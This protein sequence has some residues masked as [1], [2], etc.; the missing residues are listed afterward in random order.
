MDVQ[1]RL[2]EELAAVSSSSVSN[3]SAQSNILS[4]PYLDH[5]I[6]ETLRL[7]PPNQSTVRAAGEDC[8][9]PTSDGTEVFIRKGQFIHIAIEGF[10]TRK[11]VWGTDSFVFRP[12]R[13]AEEDVVRALKAT[14]GV[15]Q[16]LMTFSMGP[17]VRDYVLF[18][19]DEAHLTIS[20]SVMSR[21]PTR[22][23]RDEGLTRCS[24]IRVCVRTS[25]WCQSGDEQCVS[26]LL[27]CL[28]ETHE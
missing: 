11:D 7:V 27:K 26:Q 17:H 13:W 18:L 12:E 9:I 25:T 14:P 1:T 21:L 3:P 15:V 28:T 10:N 22:N 20:I 2:R 23:D 24:D 4:L 8:V 19:V 16:G 6:K 5:V